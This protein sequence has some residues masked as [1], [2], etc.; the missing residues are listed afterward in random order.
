MLERL[1]TGHVRGWCLLPSRP[2]H[3]LRVKVYLCGIHLGSARCD[4]PRPDL[5]SII[6]SEAALGGFRFEWRKA[7]TSA[8]QRALRKLAKLP[9]TENA[10][11]L[12]RLRIAGT[13]YTV[14]DEHLGTLCTPITVGQLLAALSWISKC[15]TPVGTDLP[16]TP[17]ASIDKPILIVIHDTEK[18]GA[19][20]FIVRFAEW[21]KRQNPLIALEFLVTVK[22]PESTAA[23]DKENSLADRLARLGPVYYLDVAK[24]PENANMLLGGGYK[25]IYL[26]SLGSLYCLERVPLTPSP[27]LVHVHELHWAASFML[28]NQMRQHLRDREAH[29]VACS[30]AVR[31]MLTSDPLYIPPSRVALVHSFVPSDEP[32]MFDPDSDSPQRA[33]RTPDESTILIAGTVSWRKGG[34]LL[35]SVA[36][37]LSAQYGIKPRFRWVGAQFERFCVDAVR[38]E[39]EQL[40]LTHKLELVGHLDDVAACYR[41]ADLLLLPSVEDPFPLVMIEAGLTGLPIVA[42]SGS[43]GGA[44]FIGMRG[45]GVAVPHLDTGRMAQAISELLQDA[46]YR[47]QLGE[48]ARK[49]ARQFTDRILAPRLFDV[50]NARAEAASDSTG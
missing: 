33:A 39:F 4:T 7:S 43:G 28:D 1:D 47:S 44:E 41:A 6:G 24:T 23:S 30:S 11:A 13:L 22:R 32:C 31:D 9:V 48:R 37:I 10:T 16:M 36:A 38:Y 26:N 42:F 49:T 34:Y 50:V 45:G 46:T 5:A 14:S 3:P 40:K 21:M 27:L 17:S 19:Q 8:L 20:L 25:L 29:F 2:G 35:G 15:L 18:F 12:V